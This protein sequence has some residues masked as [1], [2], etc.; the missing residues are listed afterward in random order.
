LRRWPFLV[1]VFFAFRF[2][3]WAGIVLQLRGKIATER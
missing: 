2:P 3:I 1:A